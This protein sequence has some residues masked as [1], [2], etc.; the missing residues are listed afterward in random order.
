MQD[1]K[2]MEGQAVDLNKAVEE[3]EKEREAERAKQEAA[4]EAA[5]V[6]WTKG[7]RRAFKGIFPHSARTVFMRAAEKR[8]EFE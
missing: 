7:M 5:A 6:A 4:L 8:G 1:L 3:R 2:Q